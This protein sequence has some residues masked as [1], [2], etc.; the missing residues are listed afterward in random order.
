MLSPEHSS[1]QPGGKGSQDFGGK[2]KQ[3]LSQG[4]RSTAAIQTNKSASKTF[5]FQT[6]ANVENYNSNLT[7]VAVIESKNK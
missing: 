3:L 5:F 6:T 4:Y 2:L 7:S 1:F